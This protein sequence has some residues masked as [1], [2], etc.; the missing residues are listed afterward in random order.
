MKD[1][2]FRDHRRSPRVGSENTQTYACF[3]ITD[4]IRFKTRRREL[5]DFIEQPSAAPR[6]FRMM[7]GEP[8]G[9][10]P[11]RNRLYSANATTPF[12]EKEKDSAML[13]VGSTLMGY[14]VDASDGKIGVVS[15][16]LFDD[17]SWKIRWLRG[18]RSITRRRCISSSSG[19]RYTFA[20][21]KI[22]DSALVAM[23]W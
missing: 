22:C 5:S 7:R 13:F 14:A 23:S 11:H 9:E 12:I 10:K 18:T 17:Q 8:I 19:S 4:D 6:Q 21:S 16:F 1:L 3:E 20:K 2:Q 15:D